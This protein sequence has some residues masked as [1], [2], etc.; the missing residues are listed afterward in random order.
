MI[1]ISYPQIPLAILTL[2]SLHSLSGVETEVVIQ[3]NR[4]P[5]ALE[6]ADGSQT[7]PNTI[8]FGPFGAEFRGSGNEGRNYLRTIEDG[9][10]ESDFEASVV[11]NGTGQM[12]F[13]IG[14]GDLGAYGT[15]DWQVGR[16]DS[17]WLEML[18]TGGS[19]LS[20]ISNAYRVEMPRPF[21]RNHTVNRPTR[22]VWRYE[23]DAQTLQFLA[24]SDYSGGEFIADLQ[25]QAIPVDDLFEAGESMRI[26]FGGE[27]GTVSE[28]KIHYI[29]EPS[30]LAFSLGAIS[31]MSMFRRRSNR[32]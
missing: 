30:T 10:G 26:F 4:K 18:P 3:L 7:R 32:I 31:L 1:R 6:I 28:A 5:A 11:W 29:P 16:N 13:G 20:L 15:P 19:T 8:Q 27:G 24:D 9:F 12:F 17:I 21:Q 23:A 14:G 22:I 25:S 2:G